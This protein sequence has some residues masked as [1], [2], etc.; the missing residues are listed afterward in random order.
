M[1][2]ELAQFIVSGPEEFANHPELRHARGRIKL[3]RI[4]VHYNQFIVA[5][6][7][8]SEHDAFA[9]ADRQLFTLEYLSIILQGLREVVA[10]R[11]QVG[12]GIQERGDHHDEC[13]GVHPA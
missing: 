8:S 1:V 11:R 3:R 5:E 13:V 12:A 7:W 2:S 4:H 6:E 9:T 10:D